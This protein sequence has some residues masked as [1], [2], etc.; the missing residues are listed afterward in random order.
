[1]TLD[2]NDAIR[3]RGVRKAYGANVALDGVDLTVERGEVLA[4][5]GPNGAGKTTLVEIL[6]GH[7]RADAGDVSVLGYDPAKREREFR[8]RIGIVLQETGLDAR[9]TV[10]EAVELYSAAYPHPRPAAEVLELV[11]LDGREKARAADLSGGQRRRLDLALGIAGDPELIFLD[12]PTTGFDPAARRQSWSLIEGLRELGKTI[13]LTTHYMDEAQH[14]AD[15]V[16]V[17]ADGRVLA[18]D[19]PNRLGSEQGVVTFRVVPGLP[20]P[21]GAVVERGIARLAT[22]HVTREL[23]PVLQWAAA[24]DIELDDLSITRPSLEDVYLELTA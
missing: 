15:R 8:A 2:A 13:L 20:V 22:T 23:A 18:D 1:M 19:T 6:E 24:H 17:L 16:V 5:L 11:G 4:L 3:V 12:E 10:R 9:I 21:A 14:L 7:R